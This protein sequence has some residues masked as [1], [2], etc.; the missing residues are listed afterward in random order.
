MCLTFQIYGR[1]SLWL[2][3]I[4]KEM[5]AHKSSWGG[6]WTRSCLARC[7]HFWIRNKLRA[8][9]HKWKGNTEPEPQRDFVKKGFINGWISRVLSLDEAQ[10]PSPLAAFDIG[11]QI[12]SVFNCLFLLFGSQH[13]AKCQISILDQEFSE[14]RERKKEGLKTEGV[15]ES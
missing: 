4:Y 2:P 13:V 14:W 7:Y 12:W 11:T 3:K 8:N 9:F 6:V 1:I 5:P 10:L 15:Y